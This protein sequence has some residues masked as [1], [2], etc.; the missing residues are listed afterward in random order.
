MSYRSY[1]Q[2]KTLKAKAE[3]TKIVVEKVPKGYT[4]EVTHMVVSDLARDDLLYELGYVDVAGEDRRLSADNGSE[5]YV[6]ELQGPAW[7]E[8]GEA[9]FGRITTPTAGDALM[10]SCHGKLWP[11]ES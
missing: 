11:K 5:N 8:E 4:L 6:C 10:F 9:P 7:I 2:D 3:V 1:R